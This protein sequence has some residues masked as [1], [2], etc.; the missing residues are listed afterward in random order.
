M[1][2]SKIV[3]LA[4]AVAGASAALRV[5]TRRHNWEQ[6]NNQI[7]V[8]IDFDDVQ[9][10]AIRAGL[11]FAHL[12]EKLA[13]NG[14]T[15]LSLPEWTLD[16]LLAQGR[17]TP[18]APANPLADAPEVGH[19]NYLHGDAKLVAYLAQE[20]Q[21][22]LPFTKA[23]VLN[24]TTLAFGGDL[25]TIG[26][27]GLGFD[28][29]TAVLIQQHNLSVVP[30]P[31]S[32]AWPQKE[33]LER[34]LAQAAAI[35]KTVAFDGNMILGHEMHLDETVAALEE[36]G[37]TFVYFSEARHQKGDWFIAKRRAPHIVLGHFFSPEDMVPLDFH[38]ACHN[39][40]HFAKERGIRFCYV[41]F[42]RILH[43]TAPL[44]GI[45][46]VHH[47]K[48]ALQDAG[49]ELSRDVAMPTPVPQPDTQ[50]LAMAGLAAA[51][52]GATAVSDLFNLPELIA[53][54]LTAVAA[55]GAMALPHLEQKRNEAAIARLADNHGHHHDHSH[56]HDDDHDH[57]HDHGDLHAL[58][59]PSYTPK[60][61][62]LGLAALSPM[63]GVNDPTFSGWLSSLVAQAAAAP[64]LATINS[65][66]AYQLRIEEY[67]GFNLDWALPLTAVALRIPNRAARAVALASVA[68]AWMA[69]RKQ[70]SFRWVHA[71]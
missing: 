24:D 22:R 15:H 28:E 52:I 14:A 61:L 43:A 20:L 8:C 33:L 42:F 44:E 1:K 39:W 56:D 63:V 45:D 59:P 47:L 41:N 36:T 55:A 30:R 35:G 46:Y 4:T 19:W 38:A 7:A 5:L 31:V 37:L 68:G 53:L 21:V 70:R 40:A 16:R 18:Q 25:P 26:E 23:V 60:L 12:L 64:A 54:P 49:Y 57:G 66:Q 13:D 69:A 67:R 17:L 58:Y 34:T 51:G 32:Y 27:L 71:N 2:I 65:G 10:A 48:H 3:S 62:G 9:A 6:R 29:E 11:P 50:E